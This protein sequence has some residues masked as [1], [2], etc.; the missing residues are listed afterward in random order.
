[1]TNLT[2]WDWETPE[3]QVA[4]KDWTD[5]FRWV[6]EPYASPDGEKVAAIVDA[7]RKRWIIEE[8]FKA[9]KT[10]CNYQKHQ[11]E[12]S[13]TLLILLAIETAISWRMLLIRWMAHNNPDAPGERILNSTQILLLKKLTEQKKRK[14]PNKMTVSYVLYAIAELG[15]HIKNNGPPGWLV[16][17]RGL[18][19]LLSI[20]KGW[21]LAND[22]AYN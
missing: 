5:R 16:L 8:F 3:K 18:D 11:L 19:Q 22:A 7:Y 4:M 10:G 17:R 13:K 21:V 9:L 1:M 6:E 20:E 2:D 14:I 12:S 15:G